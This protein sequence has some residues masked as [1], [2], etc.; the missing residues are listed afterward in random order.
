MNIRLAQ[1]SDKERWNEL[2]LSAHMSFLQTWQ[3]GELQKS[4]G[5]TFWRYVGEDAGQI[6][7]VALV[8]KQ[9]LPQGFSWLYVPGVFQIS[10]ELQKE[11]LRLATQEKA[12]FIRADFK[13]ESSVPTDWKKASR[14][15]QPKDTLVL[16]LDKSEE[17]LLAEMHHKTRYNIRLAG[18]RGVTTRFSTDVKDV[19]IFL[20]LARRV[21]GRSEFSY[22][23]DA[24][25]RKLLDVLG[26]EGMAEIAIA[27][28]E[29][30]PLAA[31][32]MLYAGE[33]A[34]YVH[35]ASSQEKRE[36]MAPQLLYWET[37]RRAKAKGLKTFD[38]Y[39]VAPEDA[40]PNHP[41]AGI[42][43]V[44]MGFGGKRVTYAGAYDLVTKPILYPLFH[45]ARK[46]LR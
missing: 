7:E 2:V 42:T 41:W 36:V 37:I 23:P 24:Y 10:S 32:I 14:E 4:L 20:D 40:G 46:L 45:L 15:V 27:E 17:E 22:H 3:W 34:T 31:H 44:K 35:G 9:E 33:G 25:Y 39:G 18:K 29:G 6:K 1:E 5:R 38:L 43:R 11:L 19:E 28:H 13:E 16:D 12:L 30:Q 8:I 21:T 26:K